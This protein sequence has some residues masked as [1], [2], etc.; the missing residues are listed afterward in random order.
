MASIIDRSSV[1]QDKVLS[2]LAATYLIATR[3]LVLALHARQQLNALDDV[4][5]AKE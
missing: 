5:L 1:E 4:F 3:G 2:R